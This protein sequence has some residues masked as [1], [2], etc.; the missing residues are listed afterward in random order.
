LSSSG[1]GWRARPR[2]LGWSLAGALGLLSSAVQA[3][4]ATILAKQTQNPIADLVSIPFQF[5][6]TSGGDL[7]DRTL[8]VLNLQPVLPLPLTDAWRVVVRPVIPIENVPAPNGGRRLGLG[9]IQPQLYVTP[10][11]HGAFVWGVGP[12]LSL[13]TATNDLIRTGQWG[14]GPA[15]VAVWARGNWVLGLL[16][17]NVWKVAGSDRHPKINTLTVQPFV[18]FNFTHGWALNFS[19]L[20][21]ANWG[22]SKGDRWTVPLGGGVS[23]VHAIGK[24]AVNLSF[25]YYRHVVYQNGAG[26]NQVRL[27]LSFLFPD[28]PPP[29]APAPEVAPPLPPPGTPAPPGAAPMPTPDPS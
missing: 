26:A 1:S 13:P 8:S 28:S 11:R 7:K 27:V 29:S 9:D 24:Q 5:N 20:I 6:Y 16:A 17:N 23:K 21:T 4:E 10:A 25:Q 14:L 15:G 18:N 12:I 22:Q 3:Q 19:P 2:C